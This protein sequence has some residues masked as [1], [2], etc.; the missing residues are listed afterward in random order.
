MNFTIDPAQLVQM[1]IAVVLPL[2]VGLVTTRVTSAAAKAVLLAAL[3]LATSLLAALYDAIQ[4]HETYDLGAALTLALPTFLIAV[5][6]HYGFW[7][8]TGATVAVQEA[9]VTPRHAAK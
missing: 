6:T 4:A 3:S 5:G 9:G 2:V 1:L 8:P 7:K